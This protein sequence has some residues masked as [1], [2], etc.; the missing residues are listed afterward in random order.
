MKAAIVG[1]T[2]ALTLFSVSV[3]ALGESTQ[4]DT[5]PV[6]ET[7]VTAPENTQSGTESLTAIKKPAI[8]RNLPSE[9]PSLLPQLFQVTLGLLFVLLVIITLAWLFRRFGQQQLTVKGN[10]RIV[11]GLHLSTREKVVLLQV[12]KQQ[13]LLGVAPGRI[14]KLHLLEEP[15]ELQPEPVMPSAFSEKLAQ[16]L[17]GKIK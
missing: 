9:E 3:A 16:I 4:A 7:A 10:M 11:G 17:K 2:L 1:L 14:S 5:S 8:K 6:K 12:G 15:L 13:I